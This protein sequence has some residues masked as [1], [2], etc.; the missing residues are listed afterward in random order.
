MGKRLEAIELFRMTSWHYCA[1]MRE[2]ERERERHRE[3]EREREGEREREREV[4]ISGASKPPAPNCCP[5]SSNFLS[6]DT[7]EIKTLA[8]LCTSLELL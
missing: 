7:R 8:R 3:R 4:F 6:A 1:E 5:V 2:G